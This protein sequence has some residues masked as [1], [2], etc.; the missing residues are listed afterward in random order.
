MCCTRLAANTGCKISPSAHRRITFSDYVF[1]TKA[2]IGKKLIKQQY[3]PH[4]SLQYGELRATNSWD[5][6][7]SLGHLSKCQRVSHLGS[8]TARHSS[9]GRHPNFAAFNRGRHLYSAG[10]SSHWH[11]PIFWF[12]LFLFCDLTVL[13]DVSVN[14]TFLQC[15]VCELVSSTFGCLK[16]G[17]GYS[18][19]SSKWSNTQLAVE[20]E[21]D[22]C[23]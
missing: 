18:Q 22:N 5:L 11:W 13:Y 17:T 20:T 1:V 9:S 14:R 8:V 7:A 16:C 3:L 2:F 12:L 15:S 4:M 6:L 23:R 10:R 21:P 19:L